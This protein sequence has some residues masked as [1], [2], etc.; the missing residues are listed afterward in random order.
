MPCI[1]HWKSAPRVPVRGPVPRCFP[2]T[3]GYFERSY[4][5]GMGGSLRTPAIVAYPGHVPAGQ[6]SDEIVHIT[7]MFTTLVRWAGL[8]VPRDRVIDGLDQRAFFEGK[9]KASSREGFPYWLGPT[10]YG[11]KWCNFKLVLVKQARLT[12]PAL[13]LPNPHLT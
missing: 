4:F 13:S 12:D 9:Q 8:E 3:A 10:L 6:K 5:T 7:D 1:L 11:V 2:G